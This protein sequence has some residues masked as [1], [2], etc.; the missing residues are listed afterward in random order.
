MF[1][2]EIFDIMAN[3]RPETSKLKSLDNINII[4]VADFSN[5]GDKCNN[6][7]EYGYW[8]EWHR[9]PDGTWQ[10]LE[11]TTGEFCPYCNNFNC[12]GDC[13]L[14]ESQENTR[15]SD[16]EVLKSVNDDIKSESLDVFV[17]N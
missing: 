12:C 5:Y 17:V 14:A 8:F 9:V 15:Y 2:A 7:G 13:F 10:C 3:I 1:R 16:G 6:G 11:G 4:V